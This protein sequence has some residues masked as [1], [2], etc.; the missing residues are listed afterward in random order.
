MFITEYEPG[1]RIYAIYRRSSENPNKVYVFGKGKV[2]SKEIPP[3]GIISKV[4]EIDLNENQMECHKFQMDN[5]CI[6]WSTYCQY[7]GIEEDVLSMIEGM[8][9]EEI[10]P[11]DMNEID[12]KEKA[13]EDRIF[14]ETA[15]NIS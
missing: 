3:K 6:V 13:Y 5:G 8:E 14:D 12:K 9:K 1:T 7:W 10:K 11:E 4:S 2:L 15:K